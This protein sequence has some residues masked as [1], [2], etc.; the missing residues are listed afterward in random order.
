MS[1]SDLEQSNHES[2]CMSKK[3]AWE[4]HEGDGKDRKETEAK[5]EKENV[6][7]GGKG[8]VWRDGSIGTLEGEGEGGERTIIDCC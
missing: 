8:A 6:I 2:E 7:R 3:I 4:N 1:S 5:E